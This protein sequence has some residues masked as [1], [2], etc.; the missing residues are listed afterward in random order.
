[1]NIEWHWIY[2]VMGIIF[3]L[4]EVFSFT[5]YFLPLGIS[6]IITGV[7][8]LFN[9]NIYIH[10]VIFVVSSVLLLVFISKW[11]KS[12]FLKPSG[13]SF[14][15][16]V[17][18]QTGIITEVYKSSLQPGKVKIFSDTWEIHWDNHREKMLIELKIGDHV[19]VV[20]VE[21]N[22]IVIEKIKN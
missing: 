20:S 11:R 16:G 1:M 19:K 14:V 5:F 22:K 18:G 2:L 12:R 3:I 8:A 13:S 10:G 9:S 17:V 4:L 21:G 15:A 6:A 7:F